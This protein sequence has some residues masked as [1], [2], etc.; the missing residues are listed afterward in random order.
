MIVDYKYFFR[1]FLSKDVEDLK[2][3]LAFLALENIESKS[4]YEVG[5]SWIEDEKLQ[6]RVLKKVL[7]L[8]EDVISAYTDLIDSIDQYGDVEKDYFTQRR[9]TN[10]PSYGGMGG[11]VVTCLVD[12]LLTKKEFEHAVRI[13][14]NY[15]DK[16]DEKGKNI[17]PFSEEYMKKWLKKKLI[18]SKYKD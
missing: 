18:Q 8:Q 15:P 11:W 16:Q 7:V 4:Y 3:R 10:Y 6:K 5:D 2:A 1:I 17:H 13:Y 12:F 9:D 14:S